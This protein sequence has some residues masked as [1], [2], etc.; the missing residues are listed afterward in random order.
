VE[1]VAEA[2]I[3]EVFDD[4][5]IVETAGGL[6]LY[7][8]EHADDGIV[9]GEPTEVKLEYK[10][11]KSNALKTIKR[12]DDELTVANY[13]ILY[14]GRDLEGIGSSN[15]NPDGS[16]GEYFTA[17]T[18]LDS[19]YTKAGSLCVDWEHAQG[20]AGDDLLGVVNWKSAKVDDRGVFVERVLNR[21]NQYVQWLEELGWFDSGVLGTSSQA[22]PGS[23][24]KAADGQ[25]TRWP[26][27]RDTITVQPME[28]RMITEN[29]LEVFKAL[30]IPTLAED[31]IDA[32]EASAHSTPD[33]T[34]GADEPEP[35]AAP[36]ADPSAVA[37]VK[38][39]LLRI[40]LSL[41]EV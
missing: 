19:P 4:H 40:R 8:Y 29:Q 11:A 12:T 9:F 22:E 23:V 24:E 33:D 31:Y 10:P 18:V 25:I 15:I 2:W 38:A 27:V 28:P 21:R 7:P 30:G 6:Y 3:K 35:E 16:L 14:G 5:V 39:R 37:A 17:D 34:G 1:T 36:E 13:I 32:L 20:E 41:L 26:L